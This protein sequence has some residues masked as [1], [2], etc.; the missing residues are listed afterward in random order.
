MRLPTTTN[1]RPRQQTPRGTLILHC[2]MATMVTMAATMVATV[3]ATMVATVAAT[4][5]QAAMETIEFMFEDFDQ[6]ATSEIDCFVF[7]CTIAFLS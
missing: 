5:A 2:T 3:A 1:P 6:S 7:S 4:K